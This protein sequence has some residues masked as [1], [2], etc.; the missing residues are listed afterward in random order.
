MSEPLDIVGLKEAAG[1]A[2]INVSTIST[3]RVRGRLPDADAELACGPIWR[4]ETIETWART[5]SR[6]PGPPKRIAA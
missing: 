1:I 6:K 2:G 4:R 3:F 5:R